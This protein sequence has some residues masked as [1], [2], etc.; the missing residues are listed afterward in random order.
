MINN[1]LVKQIIELLK[2]VLQFK[3]PTDRLLTTF[4][5]ESR[6]LDSEDRFIVAE[7]IYSVLRNY[8]K[9]TKT[10]NENDLK[11]TPILLVAMALVK[12]LNISEHQLSGVS[13]PEIERVKPFALDQNTI[14]LPTWV[15]DKLLKQ[16][17]DT[18]ILKLSKSFS[19][20][21]PLDLRVN[22]LKTS[23]DE[24]ISELSEFKATACE[25]SPFG[26]RLENKIFLSKHPLFT[27]GSIEVQDESSQLSGLLLNPKRGEW[28][29]D[30][31]AGSGGK[32]LL[33]GMLMRNTGR[34][35]AF[36]NNSKRL[37]NLTPRL[38]R[39]GLSNIHPQL[40]NDEV[41]SKLK[42]LHGK[43]DRVFVDAPCSGLGTMRRNPDIKFRNSIESIHELNNKQRSIL[44]AAG[45]LVKKGGYLLYATCS[46]LT[47]ENQDIVEQFL[48][49]NSGF[50]IVP[51]STVL[52]DKRLVRNDGYLVL[53]PHIHKT[54]GFFAALLQKSTG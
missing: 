19:H 9:L 7:T 23:R 3:E 25:L 8:F 32:T 18:E 27:S 12:L 35:Y 17:T 10:L 51:A 38:A 22:T 6:R 4:F 21:A 42:R 33:I 28:I 37:N 53:L 50:K 24:V 40:I 13:L 14:E 31:C 2:V 52:T 11:A 5:R 41:D 43:I 36:D 26:V 39:S 49:E 15:Y 45:K 16:M 46:I 44:H 34:I 20:E 47:E 30:F 1:Q 29:V 54:D 48:T